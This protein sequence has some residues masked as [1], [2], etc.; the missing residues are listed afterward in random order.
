MKSLLPTRWVINDFQHDYGK[1]YH[2]DVFEDGAATELAFYIQLKGQ[3]KVRRAKKGRFV[4]F[5]IKTDHARYFQSLP[6][7]MYLVIVDTTKKKAFWLFLQKYLREHIAPARWEKKKI[8]IRIPSG[9]DLAD[10]GLLLSDVQSASQYIRDVVHPSSVEAAVSAEQERLSAIDPRFQAKVS[11]LDGRKQVEFHAIDDVKGK[12][13]LKGSPE[14]IRKKFEDLLDRG[15]PVTF[16]PGEINCEDMPLWDE[17]ISQTTKLHVRSSTVMDVGFSFCDENKNI[18]YE[19]RDK[20]CEVTGGRKEQRF[21]IQE[22]GSPILLSSTLTLEKEPDGTIARQTYNIHV[23][24]DAWNG[25]TINDL[26]YFKDVRD[27][28][29]AAHRTRFFRFRVRLKGKTVLDIPRPVNGE[30]EFPAP[31]REYVNLLDRIRT[32]CTHFGIN[33]VMPDGLTAKNLRDLEEL[34]AFATKEKYVYSDEPGTMTFTFEEKSRGSFSE[35][36]IRG[37][38]FM[39]LDSEEVSYEFLG[40]HFSLSGLRRLFYDAKLCKPLE[41]IADDGISPRRFKSDLSYSKITSEIF[42]IADESQ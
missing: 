18:L 1:D 23:S 21:T 37:G 22:P 11:F 28:L 29:N 6:L 30:A 13:E 15:L 12:F 5:S 36:Q 32:V 9:N 3:T 24:Y 42:S 14:M 4:S 17:M 16:K 8:T 39:N 40:E 35:D 33:P 38:G 7:P 41:I 27:L 2:I 19:L 26:P 25:T 10:L 31:I 34:E 20:Q